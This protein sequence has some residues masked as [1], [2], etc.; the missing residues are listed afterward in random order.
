MQ[1]AAEHSWV[2]SERFQKLSTGDDGVWKVK[3]RSPWNEKRL[4][5]STEQIVLHLLEASF[6]GEP[7]PAL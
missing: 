3:T 5:F 7:H 1:T 4:A 2:D 6:R